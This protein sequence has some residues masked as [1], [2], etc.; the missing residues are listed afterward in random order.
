MSFITKNDPGAKH[1]I[2]LTL[3]EGMRTPVGTGSVLA[4]IDRKKVESMYTARFTNIL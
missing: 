2:K 4:R 1:T 3:N